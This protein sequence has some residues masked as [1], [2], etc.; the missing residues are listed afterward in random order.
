[1]HEVIN[2]A[3][4]VLGDKL[5]KALASLIEFVEILKKTSMIVDVLEKFETFS[6]NEIFSALQKITKQ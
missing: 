1:M 6:E 5:M 4:F 3:T 2:N